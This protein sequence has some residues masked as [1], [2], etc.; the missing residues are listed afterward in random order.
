MVTTESTVN[1]CTHFENAFEQKACIYRIMSIKHDLGDNLQTVV[2][3]SEDFSAYVEQG[4][5]IPDAS[6]SQLSIIQ[7]TNIRDQ[8]VASISLEAGILIQSFLLGIN[9]GITSASFYP[10]TFTALIFQQV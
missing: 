10:S 3:L 2:M 5:N 1:I 8:K 4:I 6:P 7:R 9:Q